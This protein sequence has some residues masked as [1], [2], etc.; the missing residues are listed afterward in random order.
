MLSCSFR[1]PNICYPPR[2]RSIWRNGKKIKKEENEKKKKER[3]GWSSNK[4]SLLTKMTYFTHFSLILRVNTLCMEHQGIYIMSLYGVGGKWKSVH[5]HSLSVYRLHVSLVCDLLA[6]LLG[7]GI[8]LDVHTFSCLPC[9]FVLLLK[10]AKL[11]QRFLGIS[12]THPRKTS[13]VETKGF[14]GLATYAKCNHASYESE[15]DPWFSLLCLR[16][17]KGLV[18]EVIVNLKYPII[19]SILAKK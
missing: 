14:K 2:Q 6:R 8:D 18:V 12:S 5:I 1:S 3:W 17:S 16:M 13:L 10:N 19:T 4:G 11:F 15:L 9:T 7:N